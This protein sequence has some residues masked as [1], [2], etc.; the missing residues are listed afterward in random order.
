VY[1]RHTEPPLRS[2]SHT[3]LAVAAGASQSKPQRLRASPLVTPFGFSRGPFLA[4][5]GGAGVK[6]EIGGVAFP[7]VPP[8]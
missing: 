6:T 4:C 2:R 1:S 7:A 3:N 5:M 8:K